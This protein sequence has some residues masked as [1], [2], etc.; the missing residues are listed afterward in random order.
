MARP[1]RPYCEH[2]NIFS[3]CAMPALNSAYLVYP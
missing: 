3:G 1:P 2:T